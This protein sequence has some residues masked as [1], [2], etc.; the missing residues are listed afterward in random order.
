M[1]HK[2][3]EMRSGALTGFL[4]ALLLAALPA[5][6]WL[7]LT[8]LAEGALRRQANDLN[9]VV[10]SVRSYYASNVVG[11]ILAHPGDT[12]VVHNY[13]TI[14]G[15]IPIPATLSLELGKVISEQQQNITYRF[16]SDFPFKNRAP[17]PLDEFEKNALQSLRTDPDQKIVDTATSL[18]SDRV[19]LVAP[20]LMGTACVS[21]HNSHPESPKR[22]WKVG[23]VRGIQEVSITQ[24]IAANLFSFK[25]L[26]AYF[27]LAAISGASFLLMQRRQ[28]EKIQSMNRELE[29]N[30]DF[31]ASL[32][33]KIS[34][35]IP[36]QVYKSIFS[37]QKDVTIHTERKKL[38]IFFSDIQNFTATTE[39]LQPEQIT[40]LLNEY[41]T[42][43]SEIAHQHGGTIDKFIGDAM[44]IFFGDIPRPGV[45]A[46][47][48]RPACGWPGTCSA[49]CSSS[50]PNGARR[51]SS[52][53]SSRGWA[54]I[55]AIAM[56]AISAAR[57]AW[58]IRS[59]APRPIWRRGCNRSPNPAAL[60]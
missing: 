36:P 43:M 9:S 34:R 27:A 56:S 28:A 26:L 37:G 53:R 8:N 22:D 60:C 31:L 40:Q 39:R 58:T 1:E 50:M 54:S 55:P 46:P 51:A 11:R 10:S 17:H 21:C 44:L 29:S 47:T 38:T 35:Y 15:A 57:T 25:Y 6:V 2:P 41:F 59:S 5:A 32:S 18:F 4:I 52:S 19:R 14:P 20:V 24:P 45:T 7:D 12:K 3:N 49:A 48:P 16:V 30:N 42:E 13:E 23:D 33:L